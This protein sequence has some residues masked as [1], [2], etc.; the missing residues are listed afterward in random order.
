MRVPLTLGQG[1]LPF[2]A[3]AAP[4][5]FT[6]ADGGKGHSVEERPPPALRSDGLLVRAAPAKAGKIRRRSG[7][8]AI[9]PD[10]GGQPARIGAPLGQPAGP[11]NLLFAA[12]NRVLVVPPHRPILGGRPR[13][14]AKPLHHGRTKL[15]RKSGRVRLQRGNHAAIL[16]PGGG[17]Q[18]FLSRAHEGRARARAETRSLPPVPGS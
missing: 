4:H 5:A 11:L 12:G 2:A 9:V 17:P 6:D 10:L 1:W 13:G 16:N 3:G 15:F 7:S 18:R 14:Q 8:Y